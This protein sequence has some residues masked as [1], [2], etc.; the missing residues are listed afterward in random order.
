MKIMKTY[1]IP[2]W[3][4]YLFLLP[5]GMSTGMA[6]ALLEDFGT[7]VVMR[8]AAADGET[9]MSQHFP[10]MLIIT[11]FSAIA[12]ITGV[13]YAAVQWAARSRAAA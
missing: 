13:I 9:V 7:R 1:P 12:L 4:I 10:W 3:L 2:V 5:A 8:P 11:W 6:I